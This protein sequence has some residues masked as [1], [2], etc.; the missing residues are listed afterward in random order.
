MADI[1]ERLRE[2][3]DDKWEGSG[4]PSLCGEAADEI[5]RLQSLLETANTQSSPAITP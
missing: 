4:S 1:V 2:I 5:E 3:E